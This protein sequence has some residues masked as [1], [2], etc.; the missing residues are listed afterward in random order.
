MSNKIPVE[1]R[2]GLA[3]LMSSVYVV[4]PY[5][6]KFKAFIREALPSAGLFAK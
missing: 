5:R 1:I 4:I 3:T 6:F 2:Y